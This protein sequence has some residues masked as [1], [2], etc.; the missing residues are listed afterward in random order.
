VPTV[1]A[2][3]ISTVAGGATSYAPVSEHFHQLLFGFPHSSSVLVVDI[4]QLKDN[5]KIRGLV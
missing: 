1:A 3:T 4:N 5:L 2:V